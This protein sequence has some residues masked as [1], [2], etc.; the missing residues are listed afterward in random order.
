[1]AA[2]LTLKGD[3]NVPIA[4]QPVVLLNPASAPDTAAVGPADCIDT[5]CETASMSLA[6]ISQILPVLRVSRPLTVPD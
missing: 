3:D 1:M 5:A 4:D 2:V 6:R